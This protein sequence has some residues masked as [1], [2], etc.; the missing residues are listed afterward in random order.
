MRHNKQK[1]S[2]FGRHSGPRKALLRGLVDSLVQ[3]ERIKTTLSKA[4]H[5][6]PLIERAIT[7]GKRG[8]IHSRRKL[9]ARYPHKNTVNKIVD[10]LSPRFKD[11]LGGYTRIIKLGFR[12]GDQAPLAYLEFVDYSGKIDPLPIKKE[13]KKST[14]LKNKLA[15]KKSAEK[16]TEKPT[17]KPLSADKKSSTEPQK[18]ADK[19]AGSQKP[20]RSITDKKLKKQLLA[21]ADKKRKKARLQEK[22]SRRL[23][24]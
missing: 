2:S 8:D 6:R 1:R 16:P 3:H 13:E 12:N 19:K 10:I 5:T 7:M 14:E 18:K 9:F 4:K 24:R 15:D 23:N 20:K 22:K 17:E 11:R 21:K